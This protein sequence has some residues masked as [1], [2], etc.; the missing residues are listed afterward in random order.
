MP[1]KSFDCLQAAAERA[2]V[3]ARHS[4][5]LFS[6]PLGNGGR[7]PSLYRWGMG[8][9]ASCDLL[10]FFFLPLF[11]RTNSRSLLLATRRV[12]P[13]KLRDSCRLLASRHRTCN[14]TFQPFLFLFDTLSPPLPLSPPPPL[15]P[16][17]LP[18]FTAMS[19]QKRRRAA[20]GRIRNNVPPVEDIINAIGVLLLAGGNLIEEAAATEQLRN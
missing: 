7:A 19:F 12:P 15:D 3:I 16:R 9:S 8:Q 13:I 11:F 1:L 5:R 6:S 17:P 18:K 20:D 4:S 14:W 2:T 10:S